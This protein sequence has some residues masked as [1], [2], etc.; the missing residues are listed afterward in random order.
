MSDIIA[1]RAMLE[2]A[3]SKFEQAAT[4]YAISFEQVLVAVPE[5][6]YTFDLREHDY[7]ATDISSSKQYELAMTARRNVLDIE[8]VLR[9]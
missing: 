4:C 7:C 6:I 9:S 3:L 2:D 8:R 5:H 1:N